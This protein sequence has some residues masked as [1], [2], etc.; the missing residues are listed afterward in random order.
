M[1]PRF[2]AHNA[3][4]EAPSSFPQRDP[5]LRL[6]TEQPLIHRFALLDALP[7][8]VPGIYSITGGRQV[9]K[10]TVLKQWMADLLDDGTPSAHISYLTGELIDDHHVLVRLLEEILTNAEPGPRY[11]LLD[12]V[13]YVTE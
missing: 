4:F 2:R 9:G 6:L 11:L 10:T 8:G 7:R 3:H 12:E 1:D 5:Q 13:T